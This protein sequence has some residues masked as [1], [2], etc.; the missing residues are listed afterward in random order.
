MVFRWIGSE[1]VGSGVALVFHAFHVPLVAR[2]PI[3]FVSV[4]Y[5]VL[6][7]SARLTLS[8]LRSRLALFTPVLNDCLELSL[9]DCP[10]FNSRVY[11]ESRS[12][13]SSSTAEP[14]PR[15]GGF[16]RGS[17]SGGEK[18]MS[19]SCRVGFALQRLSE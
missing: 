1:K 8:S 3:S 10:E 12:R 19:C 17:Q 6:V 5:V 4:L 11:D 13:H 7:S 9:H 16:S 18:T 15:T 2:F 14:T